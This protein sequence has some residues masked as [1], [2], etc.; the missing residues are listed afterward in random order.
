M[1]N[2][3]LF[4][5]PLGL[6]PSSREILRAFLDIPV[7]TFGSMIGICLWLI[8]LF[9]PL[10]R[11]DRRDRMAGITYS[12]FMCFSGVF[13]ILACA[14]RDGGFAHFDI[15]L[16][17]CAVVICISGLRWFRRPTVQKPYVEISTEVGT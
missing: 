12:L 4:T 17:V 9:V 15:Y 7:S 8:I 1:S 10:T 14:G 5:N 3:E 16:S 6:L 13:L 2:M 11:I